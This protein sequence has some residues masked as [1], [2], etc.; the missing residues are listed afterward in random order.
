MDIYPEIEL[1][2]E[3][4][5]S[6]EVLR[7]KSFPEHQVT[8]SYYKQLPHMRAL[9]YRGDQLV[10][11]MGLD[12]RVVSVGDEIYK[13]LGVSDFC[14]EQSSQRHGIGTAM[15]SQLSEYASS[16]DVDFIILISDLDAFYTA[17]GYLHLSSLSSWLRIHEHKNYGIAVDQVEDLYV[18]PISG[19]TWAVG[20]IDWLGYMY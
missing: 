7:N 19:K 5:N 18:K 17:N 2:K 8:R 16:K 9:K 14:V 12:Y 10:G 4:H 6:I 13:V 15:L 1:S 11:Y 3:Q 20:H